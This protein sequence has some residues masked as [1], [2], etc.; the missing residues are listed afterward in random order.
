MAWSRWSG[1]GLSRDKAPGATNQRISSADRR[2]LARSFLLSSGRQTQGREWNLRDPSV[3][4][5]GSEHSGLAVLK[6]RRREKV[7]DHFRPDAAST[8]S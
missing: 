7:N 1:A 5:I 6:M 8:A 4:I 2:W 3:K